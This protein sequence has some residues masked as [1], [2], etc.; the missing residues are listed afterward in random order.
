MEKSKSP[1][2]SCDHRECGCHSNCEEYRE[3][4]EWN[5][6]RN[7]EI[8]QQKHTT[9]DIREYRHDSYSRQNRSDKR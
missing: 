8:R 4:S 1:C 2:R 7:A 9:H 5:V 3:W 6:N